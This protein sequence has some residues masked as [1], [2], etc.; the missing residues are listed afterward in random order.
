MKLHELIIKLQEIEKDIPSA[1]VVCD[2]VELTENS[3]SSSPGYLCDVEAQRGE[4]PRCLFI[5]G[6]R[7]RDPALYKEI[8]EKQREQDRRLK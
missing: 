6:Q 5:I 2:L 1:E 8:R 7:D 4:P 3:L